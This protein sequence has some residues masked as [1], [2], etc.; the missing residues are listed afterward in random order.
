MSKNTLT[1]ISIVSVAIAVVA[2]VTNPKV[3]NTI[4]GYLDQNKM[5][6]NTVPD[7]K[8]M[9]KLVQKNMQIFAQSVKEKDMTRFYRSIAPFWQQKTSV[10]ELN[11]VFAPFMNAAIDLTK[12]QKLQ[13][14][15]DKG[16]KLTQKQDLYILGHYN[17]KPLVRFEQT[18]KHQKDGSWKLV[19]FFLAVK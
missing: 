15:I 13:P 10:K 4:E 3:K 8:E 2:L 6:V 19:A 1:L 11:G 9:V 17:T 5:V 16:T 14:V 18:C 12:L 7:E